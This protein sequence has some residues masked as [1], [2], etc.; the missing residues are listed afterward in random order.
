MILNQPW[1]LVSSGH[2]NNIKKMGSVHFI[3]NNLQEQGKQ[4]HADLHY[5]QSTR[6]TYSFME[7]VQNLEKTK[8]KNL[9]SIN[10]VAMKGNRKHEADFK[11][12]ESIFCTI[13]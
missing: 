7:M 5:S 11:V 9:C 10:K 4:K 12:I 8:K 2:N 1:K 13:C 3:T 6:D